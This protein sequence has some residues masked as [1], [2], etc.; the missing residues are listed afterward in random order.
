VARFQERQGCDQTTDAEQ[1]VEMGVGEQDAVEPTEP[2][3][4]LQQ[5]ALGALTTVHQEPAVSVQD[6][7]RWQP[8]ST[9]G[10][11]AAVPRKTT[12]NKSDHLKT[13]I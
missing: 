11:P 9:A 1:V 6:D 12:S 3:P 4:T 8:R 13:A 5:L 10:T 2:E 7:E